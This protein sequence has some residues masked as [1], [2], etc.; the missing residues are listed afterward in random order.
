[1][2]RAGQ[3][4]RDVEQLGHGLQPLEPLLARELAERVDRGTTK[5]KMQAAPSGRPQRFLR[6]LPPVLVDD[7]ATR[8]RCR[9]ISGGSACVTKS[10]FVCHAHQ[11]VTLKPSASCF[12]I[13]APPSASDRSGG[14]SSG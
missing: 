1:D 12:I 4:E 3:D 7:L 9:K 8:L 13:L 10:V 11:M 6:D 5:I 2:F 14:G